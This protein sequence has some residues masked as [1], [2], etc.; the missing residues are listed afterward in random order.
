MNLYILSIVENYNWSATLSTLTGIIGITLLL[1]F[2]ILKIPAFKATADLNQASKDKKMNKSWYPSIIKRSEMAGLVTQIMIFAFVFPFCLTWEAQPIW[3][4]FLDTAIILMVYDFFYYLT[5]RFLFHGNGPLLK[6]HSVHHQAKVPSR[7]DSNYLHPVETF[8]GLALN[9]ACVAVL[10]YFFG[11]FHVV[12]IIITY[13]TF[14]QLNHLNHTLINVPGRYFKL[15]NWISAKHHVHHE[16]F[17]KGNYA[18]IT[19]LYDKLFGTYE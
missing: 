4:V 13:I 12:T 10:A 19:L 1:K 18:T 9:A 3:K 8:I 5:H 15:L 14:V 11:K 6:V 7:I 2:L 16:N 17:R